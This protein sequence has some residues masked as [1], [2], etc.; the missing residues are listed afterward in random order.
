MGPNKETNER[1]D[2]QPEVVLPRENTGEEYS[3]DV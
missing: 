3:V 1:N 2:I